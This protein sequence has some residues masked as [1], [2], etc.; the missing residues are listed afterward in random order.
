MLSPCDRE[1]DLS[2]LHREEMVGARLSR[3]SLIN[4]HAVWCVESG[5]S[6]V[7]A[8]IHELREDNI[9]EEEQWAEVSIYRRR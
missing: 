3:A 1:R 5:S 7:C 4:C 6:Y 2:D 9:G 8:G